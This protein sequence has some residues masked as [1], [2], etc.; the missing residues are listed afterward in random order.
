MNTVGAGSDLLPV[1]NLGHKKGGA[2][3]EN[4]T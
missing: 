2:D 3:S 4:N 1:W